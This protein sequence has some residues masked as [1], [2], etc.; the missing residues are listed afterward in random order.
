MLYLV[1]MTVKPPPQPDD[2]F[3]QLKREE[4]EMALQL[5]REGVWRHLW[6]VVG[7]YE[8]YS[9][10]D[11]ENHDALHAY[12]IALPLY[13]Y[14]DIEVTPLATHPSALPKGSS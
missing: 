12:L 7:R 9:V 13:P 5:Q 3:E 2:A 14:L 6:R 1:K 4:K 8:N 10:F 11:V